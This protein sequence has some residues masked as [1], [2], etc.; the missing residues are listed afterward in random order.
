MTPI[1]SML[2]LI[3]GISTSLIILTVA[4]RGP[5]PVAAEQGTFPGV[6]IAELHA[7]EK[8]GRPMGVSR[9]ANTGP[10]QIDTV[11]LGGGVDILVFNNDAHGVIVVPKE[12]GREPMST[13]SILPF[14]WNLDGILEP[15]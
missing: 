6:R 15:K 11:A 12:T 10:D 3:K 14:F 2:A 4:F 1:E 13:L 9:T 5:D 8:L 7:K